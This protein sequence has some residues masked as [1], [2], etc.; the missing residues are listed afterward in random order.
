LIEPFSQHDQ[1]IAIRIWQRSQQKLVDDREDRRISADTHRQRQNDG[2]RKPRAAP[3]AS[4]HM[5]DIANQIFEESAEPAFRVSAVN[6]F[7]GHVKSLRAG[8]A[9]GWPD[10]R[11]CKSAPVPV[12]AVA[13]NGPENHQ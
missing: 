7:A 3:E 8:V 11:V 9:E 6:L 2:G 1:P 4:R 5:A 13:S 12:T 10:D